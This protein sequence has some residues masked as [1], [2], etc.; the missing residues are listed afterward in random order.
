MW[1]GAIEIAASLASKRHSEEK[2]LPMYPAT[3]TKIRTEYEY[4]C[5]IDTPK[6]YLGSL[7]GVLRDLAKRIRNGIEVQ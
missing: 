6:E 2:T 1:V 5:G 4:Q 7:S 3:D